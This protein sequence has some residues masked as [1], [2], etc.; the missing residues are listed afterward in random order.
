MD[1]KSFDQLFKKA[2]GNLV[3]FL[4]ESSWRSVL[5]WIFI[6]IFAPPLIEYTHYLL[7]TIPYPLIFTG[8]WKFLTVTLSIKDDIYI[9]SFITIISL[10]GKIIFNQR[11]LTTIKENFDS[12]LRKWSIPLNSHWLIEKTTD[13]FNKSLGL[14]SSAIPGLLKPAYNWYDY[15]FT[16]SAKFDKELCFVVRASSSA[17]GIMF[18]LLADKIIPYIICDGEYIIDDKKVEELPVL[19]KTNQWI[20]HIC[21][22]VEG[23]I[24]TIKTEDINIQ[25]K[26]PSVNLKIKENDLYFMDV[27][28]SSLET[29]SKEIDAAGDRWLNLM[30]QVGKETDPSKKA[31]LIKQSDDALENYSRF[32]YKVLALDYQ[33]GSVGFKNDNKE[34]AYINNI[35]VKQ[36]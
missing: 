21:V 30:A 23:N 6:I 11:K 29:T 16:F 3:V 8:I 2:F 20:D 13:K 26:I 34:I 12:G 36:I 17:N 14:Y 1:S 31:V 19:F 28:L 9:L 15:S 32:K 25:Y 33:T 10:L 27:N 22:T 24:V 7:K 35:S 4:L 18:K 5:A